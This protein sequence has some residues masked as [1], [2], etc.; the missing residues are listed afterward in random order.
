MTDKKINQDGRDIDAKP[1]PRDC[2]TSVVNILE[3]LAARSEGRMTV[4]EFA[5]A[6]SSST[7]GAYDGGAMMLYHGNT[8]GLVEPIQYSSLDSGRT[9]RADIILELYNCHFWDDPGATLRINGDETNLRD[10]LVETTV[11]VEIA[12]R[13]W[14]F[15]FP[16]DGRVINKITL[17]SPEEVDAEHDRLRDEHLKLERQVTDMLLETCRERPLFVIASLCSAILKTDDKACE[18]FEP[19]VGDGDGRIYGDLAR[20]ALHRIQAKSA[21]DK[22]AKYWRLRDWA[23]DHA[24]IPREPYFDRYNIR[25]P[26]EFINVLLREL[27]G[28]RFFGEAI[29]LVMVYIY[30]GVPVYRARRDGTYEEVERESPDVQAMRYL[31]QTGMC[32]DAGLSMFP[33]IMRPEYY[34]K[35]SDFAAY[36]IFFHG[37]APDGEEAL[38][39]LRE[40]YRRYIGANDYNASGQSASAAEEEVGRLKR[41]LATTRNELAEARNMKATGSTMS[42]PWGEYTT[43]ALD[44]LADIGREHFGSGVR[45]DPPAA[46]AFAKYGLK[47]EESHAKVLAGIFKDQSAL[48]RKI[49]AR[50]VNSGRK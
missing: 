19:W 49:R 43:P 27:E 5:D 48:N 41:E 24:P 42:W 29:R 33:D 13:L 7:V 44:A 4:P 18:L 6:L 34:F 31:G 35:A 14:K 20:T 9:K 21:C 2:C 16:D 12:R 47:P 45:H 23:M 50:G 28:E 10:V 39:V 37:G 40:N 30:E 1:I 46:K 11:G 15:A 36:A 26:R 25:S 17:M 38:N 3:C 22:T 8:A 32:A